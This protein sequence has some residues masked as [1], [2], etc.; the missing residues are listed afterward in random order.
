MGAALGSVAR[1]LGWAAAGAV[2]LIVVGNVA[3]LGLFAGARMASEPEALQL[4]G[5]DHLR[6]VDAGLWRGDAPSTAGYEALAAAGVTT[7]VDLRPAPGAARDVVEGLGLRYEH[8][9][10][11]DGR[12]PDADLVERFLAL[13]AEDD[14]I[15]YVHCSAGVG[16]TGSMVAAYLTS[17]G[18][19]PLEV[20][21]QNLAV[22]PPSLEQVAYVLGARGDGPPPEPGALVR[23]ASR[24]IDG[25]RRIYTVLRHG[26]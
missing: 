11:R 18:V 9:P 26:F 15:V 17:R 6:V 13:V 2:G 20:L 25:P 16:R 12:T 10:V 5:I 14:G 19:A 24:L 23:A 7:V 4:P 21:Q 8:L 1:G 3:L 22:G